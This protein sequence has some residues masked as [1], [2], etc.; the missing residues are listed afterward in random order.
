MS[1]P[2]KWL[3]RH[4]YISYPNLKCHVKQGKVPL[5]MISLGEDINPLEPLWHIFSLLRLLVSVSEP[6][7]Q[8]VLC[9]QSWK[10]PLS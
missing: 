10:V 7:T 3:H 5:C 9:N 6:V 4:R 2:D 8:F 1:S